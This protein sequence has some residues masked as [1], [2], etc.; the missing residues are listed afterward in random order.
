MN[1]LL[2][3]LQVTATKRHFGGGGFGGGG[4]G[5]GGGEGGN[6]GFGYATPYGHPVTHPGFTTIA[7]PG[8]ALTTNDIKNRIPQAPKASVKT[9]RQ[10]YGAPEGYGNMMPMQQEAPE[11][12]FAPEQSPEQGP[13]MMGPGDYGSQQSEAVPAM[14]MGGGGGYS[15]KS[16]RLIQ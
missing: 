15:G 13:E 16:H 6:H 3:Y 5:G 14:P 1:K 8:H 2:F 10:V 11:Q 12:S 9:K 7:W 4:G